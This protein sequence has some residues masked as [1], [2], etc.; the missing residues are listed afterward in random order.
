[1]ESVQQDVITSVPQT[2]LSLLF[3]HA[4]PPNHR[5]TE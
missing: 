4:Q 2:E 3:L 5:I 1:M